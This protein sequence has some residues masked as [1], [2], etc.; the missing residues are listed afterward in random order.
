MTEVQHHV[1][2][3]AGFTRHLDS[4]G[5]GSGGIAATGLYADSVVTFT[6]ATNVVNLATHG[7]LAGDGP[8]Q[9]SNS[10]G[11]LPAEI[12]PLTDYWIVETVAAGTFQVALTQGGAVE[13]FTDDGT[14]TNTMETPF[15]F[16]LEA[17]A[18]EVLRVQSLLVHIQDGTG[19]VGEDY[20]SLGAA[21]TVGISLHHE[22]AL[23]ATLID[24]TD[25]VTAKSNADWGK[26][27]YGT[28]LVLFGAGDDFLQAL[29]TFDVRLT[30]GQ[31]L[32]VTCHDDLSG[33]ADHTFV[34][35]GY[36]ELTE[37][38]TQVAG[39]TVMQPWAGR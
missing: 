37:V 33:L 29:W 1:L 20:G 12:L 13:E 7:Y 24:L 18:G 35:Q 21:L 30:A 10:G 32:V 14:G 39:G 16:Y 5:D 2:H 19:F 22:D 23:G 9:F 17:A 8:F 6:N 25:G 31:K 11:A 38:W 27:C 34:A 3:H 4:R 36:D 26:Y 15:R 28:E